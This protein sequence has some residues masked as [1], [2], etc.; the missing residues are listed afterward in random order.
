M[1]SVGVFRGS[2]CLLCKVDHNSWPP[3]NFEG[4]GKMQ[5]INFGKQMR[6]CF[7]CQKK[8]HLSQ[9]CRLKTSVVTCRSLSKEILL[10]NI[11]NKQNKSVCVN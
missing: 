7:D 4:L 9:Q 2:E 5:R 3:P 10:T 1:K 6:L 8:G 11:P